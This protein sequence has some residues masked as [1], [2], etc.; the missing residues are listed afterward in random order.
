MLLNQRQALLVKKPLIALIILAFS[1][2]DPMVTRKL[3]GKPKPFPDRAIKPRSSR[4]WNTSSASCLKCKKIK[5]PC[6]G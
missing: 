4:Y 5:F 3:V 1:S 6:D 2:S